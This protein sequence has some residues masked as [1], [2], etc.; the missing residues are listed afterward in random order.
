MTKPLGKKHQKILAYLEKQK[1]QPKQNPKHSAQ[2]HTKQNTKQNNKQNTNQN[3]SNEKPKKRSREEDEE[4]RQLSDEDF[5][6]FEQY[7]EHT[8]FLGDLDTEKLKYTIFT[9]VNQLIV[10]Q[11]NTEKIFP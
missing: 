7:G 8:D 10:I 11:N 5:E 1:N 3:T 4:D 9:P 6:F 2:K